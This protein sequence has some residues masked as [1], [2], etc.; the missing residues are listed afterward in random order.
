MVRALCIGIHTT[1]EEYSTNTITY[2]DAT[3]VIQSVAFTYGANIGGLCTSDVCCTVDA[4]IHTPLYVWTHHV[5]HT[6]GCLHIYARA[7]AL[8]ADSFYL[9]K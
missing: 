5:H 2:S 6:L 8:R 9:Q 7:R 4:H 1:H 3:T